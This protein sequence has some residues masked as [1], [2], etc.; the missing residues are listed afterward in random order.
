[1][2][3]THD[4][5]LNS[6]S[7][8]FFVLTCCCSVFRVYC[9]WYDTPLFV[10]GLFS[11]VFFN[12]NFLLQCFSRVCALLFVFFKGHDAM[13]TAGGAQHSLVLTMNSLF[14]FGRNDSGQLGC[15]ASVSKDDWGSFE[16]SPMEVKH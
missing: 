5:N 11:A 10:F 4:D 13:A 8:Y 9:T 2:R 16:K 15:T 6:S 14:A 1:M 3:G 7:S 12:A